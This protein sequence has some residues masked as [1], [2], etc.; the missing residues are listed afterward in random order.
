MRA[1]RIAAISFYVFAW[2]IGGPIFFGG[3]G[4]D[5]A[6]APA[7]GTVKDAPPKS[8]EDQQNFDKMYPKTGAPKK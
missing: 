6:T 2:A 3:C 1:V 8:A 7:T 5:S 4:E